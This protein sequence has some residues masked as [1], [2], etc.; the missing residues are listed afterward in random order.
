MLELAALTS[1]VSVANSCFSA[2]K[3]AVTVGKDLESNVGTISRWMSAVSK[4]DNLE[5]AAKNPTIL[6]NIFRKDDVQSI[7]VQALV[8]KKKFE[9][10]R[11]ELKNLLNMRY[12][13][14]TYDE[15]LKIEASI[16]KERQAA[17]ERQRQKAKLIGTYVLGAFLFLVIIGAL[18]GFLF[19]LKSQG[20]F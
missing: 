15:L 8:A 12:G 10:Q 14:R 4:V 5:K 9:E 18:V 17:F 19:L 11:A 7:A 16:R 1:A 20:R 3:A 6:E 2:L 13:F